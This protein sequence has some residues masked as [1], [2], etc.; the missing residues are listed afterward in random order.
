MSESAVIARTT[1]KWTKN[2]VGSNV[3]VHAGP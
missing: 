3:P 1:A 2:D